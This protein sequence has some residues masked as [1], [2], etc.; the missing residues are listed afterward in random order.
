M[1]PL[2][3]GLAGLALSVRL[4]AAAPQRINSSGDSYVRYQDMHQCPRLSTL[5]PPE[6]ADDV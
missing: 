2:F 1:L 4:I 6:A 5:P 3:A